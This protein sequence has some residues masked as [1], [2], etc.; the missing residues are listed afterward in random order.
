MFLIAQ[1]PPN[2]ILTAPALSEKLQE[3]IPRILTAEAGEPHHDPIIQDLMKMNPRSVNADFT[4]DTE[5][6]QEPFETSIS[7]YS[8]QLAELLDLLLDQKVDEV[9]R[10]EYEASLTDLTSNVPVLLAAKDSRKYPEDHLSQILIDNYLH[11]LKLASL[12]F[13][14]SLASHVTKFLVKLIYALECWEIYH[15]L[16]IIPDIEYFL[17]LVDVDVTMTPFGHIVKPPENLMSFNLRQGFQYPFP[18]PFYN[19]S[20]HTPDPYASS[21]K[22]AKISI[23]NYIDI[24]LKKPTKRRRRPRS[25]PKLPK[26]HSDE[27]EL[28]GSDGSLKTP[29]VLRSQSSGKLITEDYQRHQKVYIFM[30]MDLNQIDH[31]VDVF[32]PEGN[33][34]EDDYDTDEADAIM[35]EENE[36]IDL[37]RLPEEK[38]IIVPSVFERVLQDAEQRGIAKLTTLHQCR[39][40]DPSNMRPCLKI[41]YGKNEL[42]RHQEFVHA[43]TKKIYKCVYCES[44][45]SKPQSYPRHDSLARHIR[46]KHGITGR[47]NKIAINLAKKNAIIVGDSVPQ[48]SQFSA[49]PIL[50]Q[51]SLGPTAPK[52]QGVSIGQ[53]SLGQSAPGY[54][55]PPPQG[56]TNPTGSSAP[57]SDSKASFVGSQTTSPSKIPNLPA[58]AQT[59]TATSTS[60]SPIYV[61][62]PP[63]LAGM[64][65][66][67]P[68]DS[69]DVAIAPNPQDLR[70]GSGVY[71]YPYPG[72][73]PQGPITMHGSSPYVLP[74][75]NK[76]GQW[77]MPHAMGRDEDNKSGDVR[78]SPPIMHGFQK[79]RF[80]NN[81]Y[82]VGMP[83]TYPIYGQEAMYYPVQLMAGQ[84]SYISYAPPPQHGAHPLHE[85][86]EIS[87]RQQQDHQQQ[88]Q[89]QQQQQSQPHDSPQQRHQGSP[90]Q[91]SPS[92][93]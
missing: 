8:F 19:F 13:N 5:M 36:A 49:V 24:R 63:N 68:F 80:P 60:K 65:Q 16:R 83:P 71:M 1:C 15:L 76:I 54:V 29:P 33:V 25:W 40:L 26:F 69:K 17:K 53:S 87:R 55:V 2:P 64:R 81:Y 42:Q 23:D 46:R 91:Q 51:L 37:S 35:A 14:M 92:G 7:E 78:Q 20:F 28:H 86:N 27:L 62:Q 48:G 41:F 44:T 72:G 73:A 74:Q 67:Y 47:E 89:Q 45:G 88:Q 38:Y 66:G 90:T 61:L 9:A 10:I 22:F 43:T 56:I 21:R 84:M 3:Q 82:Q 59:P 4:N 93:Q 79:F 34:E 75:Y 70:P 52:A 11:L 18:Y 6:A 58:S 32:Y 50:Q 39:L 31:E 12:Y 57:P 30:E 77:A 85:Q